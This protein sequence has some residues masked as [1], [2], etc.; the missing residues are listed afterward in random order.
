MIDH[1]LVWRAVRRVFGSCVVCVGECVS[2]TEIEQPSGVM[3]CGKI[4]NVVCFLT[5]LCLR[6]IFFRHYVI[7]VMVWLSQLYNAIYS[8]YAEFS[9]LILLFF[10][11]TKICNFFYTYTD[12]SSHTKGTRRARTHRELELIRTWE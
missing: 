3:I 4:Y 10:S 5:F 12:G 9:F 11:K 2:Y 6:Y 8:H 1:K 7:K